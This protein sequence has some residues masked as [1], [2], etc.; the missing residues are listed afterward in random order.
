MYLREKEGLD[1]NHQNIVGFEVALKTFRER[2]CYEV[3]SVDLI[4][5]PFPV[6]THI[7]NMVP[8]G[9]KDINGRVVYLGMRD[10]RTARSR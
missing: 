10:C 7:V 1:K 9:S 4:P 8:L 2:R 3:E 6:G 5:L